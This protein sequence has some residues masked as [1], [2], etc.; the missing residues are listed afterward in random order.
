M[1]R[2]HRND[3]PA[4][5]PPEIYDGTSAGRAEV[6]TDPVEG[7]LRDYYDALYGGGRLDVEELC[8]RCPGREAELCS[9]IDCFGDVADGLAD[10]RGSLP[11]EPGYCGEGSVTSDGNTERSGQI[12]GDFRINR[13]LGRGGMARV[14]EAEQ[15]SL[16]RRVALKILSA[17]RTL[18]DPDAVKFQREAVAGGKQ[19]HP[20]IVVLYAQGESGGRRFL[21]MELEESSGEPSLRKA[22]LSNKIGDVY[23][24]L[25][26]YSIA[27][28][29][30]SRSLAVR[31][32]LLGDEHP[33]TLA[34]INNLALVYWRQDRLSEAEDI[35]RQVLG[36]RRRVLGETEPKTLETKGNLAVVLHLRGQ[37]AEAEELSIEVVEER[38]QAVGPDDRSTLEAKHNLALVWMGLGQFKQAETMLR[39]VVEGMGLLLGEEHLATI[40]VRDGLVKVLFVKSDLVEA[41]RLIRRN[42]EFKRRALGGDHPDTLISMGD[43]T[44]VLHGQKKLPEAEGVAREALERAVAALGEEHH[45]TVT[46]MNA[47]ATALND[48]GEY[49]EAETLYRKILK[50]DLRDRGD[51][52]PDTLISLVN[53]AGTLE[54][55]GELV[56][57][58]ELLARAFATARRVLGEIHPTTELVFNGYIYF[59]AIHKKTGT[60]DATIDDVIVAWSQALGDEHPETLT[61]IHRMVHLYH[62]VGRNDRAVQLLRGLTDVA[63]RV[64]PENSFAVALYHFSY[65]VCLL[66]VNR[67]TEAE[68]QLLVAHRRFRSL[69][70]DNQMEVRWTLKNLVALYCAWGKPEKAAQYQ[71]LLAGEKE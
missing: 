52:H 46:L 18:T 48:Q 68:A 29:H 70:G 55:R 59:L 51:E 53:L 54:N 4:D 43:L 50:L 71:A 42:L 2:D 28:E 22:A 57:A 62:D 34:T 15:I 5:Q 10:K 35:N 33:D 25:G 32:L 66:D 3:L 26:L 8:R 61:R 38:E 23:Y 64:L 39:H 9:R 24:E 30:Y 11:R 37:L 7:A 6:A 13:E 58:E 20:G 31:K 19:Q 1:R 40:R 65:G 69:V 36:I 27:E 45:T 60:M 67:F 49:A 44:N 41:E 47:L 56:E 63:D 16:Q 21:A 17:E 14:F 12:L